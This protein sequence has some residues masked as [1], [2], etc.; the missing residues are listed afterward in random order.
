M[1]RQSTKGRALL[2]EGLPRR[3]LPPKWCD[4][5]QDQPLFQRR[6]DNY[7]MA[8]TSQGRSRSLQRLL[9]AIYHKCRREGG[10]GVGTGHTFQ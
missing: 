2:V 10:L 7:I 4:N 3:N 1:L 5:C 6:G 9:G 8:A